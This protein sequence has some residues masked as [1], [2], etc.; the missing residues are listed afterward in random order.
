MR[1][2]YTASPV[3]RDCNSTRFYASK[4]F[5]VA[6]SSVYICVY[7]HKTDYDYYKKAQDVKNPVLFFI[8]FFA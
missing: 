8:A 3:I 2:F 6:H 5:V 7:M 4:S 1:Q